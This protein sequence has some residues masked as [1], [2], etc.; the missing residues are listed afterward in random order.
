MLVKPTAEFFWAETQ[1]G[2]TEPPGFFPY[3]QHE[4]L[5]SHWLSSSGSPTPTQT[6]AE[7]K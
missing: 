6:P 2:Q 7:A 4:R 1:R 5:L 3:F